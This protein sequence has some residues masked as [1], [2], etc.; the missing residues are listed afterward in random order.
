MS[1]EG[2]GARAELSIVTMLFRSESWVPEFHRRMLA[3]ASRVT[4]SFEIVY[5]D[6]GSPDR[7]ATVVKE[8]VAGDP[9]VTLVEL[10]RNFGHHHAALA[11]LA[12]ACG[13]RVFIIDV[14]LEEAPEWLPD[15]AAQM[16]AGGADVVYGVNQVRQGPFVRK[17]VGGWFWK[18]FNLLSETKIPPNPCTVRLMSRRYVDALLRL[19][20]RNL[21]LAGSYAWLGFRQEPRPVQKATRPTRSSYSPV[22]LAAL[23]IDAIT[24]FTSYPLS[25]IFVIGSSIAALAMLSGLWLVVRKLVAPETISLGWPSV[26]ISIWFLGGL[27]IAFLGIIGVY[28]GKLFVEVKGRPVYV[29][30]EVHRLPAAARPS[31]DPE[32][33]KTPAAGG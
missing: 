1:T 13:E 7:A 11:G 20:D 27:T 22:R 21:F 18:L 30:R 12:H 31:G 6:D 9:R 3:A 14:D 15:F 10:S 25:L 29:V 24:S 8:L 5:V 28:L 23:F 33:T 26:I 16:E 32:V 17:Q 4:P 19:P 2:T